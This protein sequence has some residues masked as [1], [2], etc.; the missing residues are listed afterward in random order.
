MSLRE[1]FKKSIYS[2]NIFGKV[3]VLKWILSNL[4]LHYST[5]NA[6]TATKAV[7]QRP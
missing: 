5:P 3:E 2:K 1:N 4:H 6:D 7:S